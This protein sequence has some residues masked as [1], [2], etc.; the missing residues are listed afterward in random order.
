M[1]RK[2]Q[3]DLEGAGKA[4]DA[5]ELAAKLNGLMGQAIEEI[6]AGR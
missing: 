4:V 5:G 1:L 3:K 2:V 6:K